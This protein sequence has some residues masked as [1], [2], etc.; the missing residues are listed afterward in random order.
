MTDKEKRIEEI[1]SK[2][3][4]SEKFIKKFKKNVPFAVI[5]GLFFSFGYPYVPSGRGG[6]P[7][8]ETMEYT[9]AVIYML[10]LYFVI[11]LISYFYLIDK[12][13][14]NIESL[15]R[16]KTSIENRVESYKSTSKLKTKT[17]S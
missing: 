10:V 12:K 7:L 3:L 11:Y 2:I 16:T 17:K 5:G 13:K 9:D 1:D 8:I 6:K 15:K 14:E 4:K